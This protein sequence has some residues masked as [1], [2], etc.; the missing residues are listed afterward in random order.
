[1]LF[2]RDLT[3]EFTGRAGVLDV[4]D[5]FKI[6]MEE[7]LQLSDH[8]PI[9]AEFTVTEQP[10]SGNVSTANQLPAGTPWR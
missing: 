4:M 9:W 5:L 6:N 7:A 10:S 8:M 3:S 1:M 2:D